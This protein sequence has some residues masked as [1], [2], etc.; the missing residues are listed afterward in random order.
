M[1]ACIASILAARLILLSNPYHPNLI[2]WPGGK[3]FPDVLDQ[4]HAIWRTGGDEPFRQG[5]SEGWLRHPRLPVTRKGFHRE[6]VFLK[7]AKDAL[8]SFFRTDQHQCGAFRPLQ[9]GLQAVFFGGG[10]DG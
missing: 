10:R 8:P 3:N 5:V 1:M 9:K 7:C 2:S 4:G 6:V